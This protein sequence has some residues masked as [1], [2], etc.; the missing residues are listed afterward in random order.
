MRNGHAVDLLVLVADN[1]EDLQFSR[2]QGRVQPQIR[3]STHVIYA[4]DLRR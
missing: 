2:E 4:P 3:R 1:A